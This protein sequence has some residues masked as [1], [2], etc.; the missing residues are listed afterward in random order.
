MLIL[1]RLMQLDCC[2]KRELCTPPLHADPFMLSDTSNPD[3]NSDC[4][5]GWT[6]WCDPGQ[7]FSPLLQMLL[8]SAGVCFLSLTAAEQSCCLSPTA[9]F[10]MILSESTKHTFV[11]QWAADV[12]PKSVGTCISDWSVWYASVQLPAFLPQTNKWRELYICYNKCSV[13]HQSDWH[14]GVLP[15]VSD[16]A[17]SLRYDSS[18]RR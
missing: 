1:I 11:H 2:A 17:G 3:W 4:I 6:S 14:H 15:A 18:V 9:D 12:L 16:S 7:L 5:S 13:L 8:K 10:S